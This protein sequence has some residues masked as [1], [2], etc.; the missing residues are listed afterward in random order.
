MIN[1]FVKRNES[2]NK[3]KIKLNMGKELSVLNVQEMVT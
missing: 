1:D 2:E 3:S